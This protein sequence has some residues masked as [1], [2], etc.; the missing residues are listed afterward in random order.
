MYGG[1]W[2]EGDIRVLILVKCYEKFV[3][4]I[5]KSE[6]IF[7]LLH[8]YNSECSFPT[9]RMK[10][11]R[12]WS[13]MVVVERIWR[14][15]IVVNVHW[16]RVTKMF[17]MK[18]AWISKFTFDFFTQRHDLNGYFWLQMIEKGLISQMCNTWSW[19]SSFFSSVWWNFTY[20]HGTAHIY[21]CHI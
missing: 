17:G 16:I 19:K 14:I 1:N 7:S 5:F 21:T 12:S 9:Q 3:M 20:F 13:I 4:H 6:V 15:I 18:N 10:C 2:F 8:W 11:G